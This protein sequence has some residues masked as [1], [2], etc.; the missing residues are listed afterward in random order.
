MI[1]GELDGIRS[2][3]GAANYDRASYDDARALLEDTALGPDYVDFLTIPGYSRL[4][5]R[6]RVNV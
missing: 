4:M 5:G 3:L 1:D 6:E 2:L